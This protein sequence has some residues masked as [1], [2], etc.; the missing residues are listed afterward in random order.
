MSG[1]ARAAVVRRIAP[2]ARDVAAAAPPEPLDL[3]ERRA[4]VEG[5][6]TLLDGLYAHLPQKRAAYGQD[7]VQRLRVLGQRLGALDEPEF[8]RAMFEIV[9]A[10]RDGHT[11]YIGP[12]H[13]AGEVAFL[14][15]LVERCTEPDGEHVVVSKVFAADPAEAQA[16]DGAG[17]R[18]GVEVTH[19]NGVPIGRALVVYGERETGGRP[20]ARR[21]RALESLTLR[22]LRF[23]PPPDEDWV[24]VSFRDAAGAARAVRLSWRHA[25][26]SDAPRALAVEGEARLAYA[27]DGAAEAVRRVKKMLFA[28]AAWHAD[29]VAPRAAGAEAAELRD[30]LS[31]REVTCAAGTV[32]YLRLWSV[33]VRDDDGYLDAV[34]RLLADLPRRGLILDLRGNPGGLIWAAERL[35]QFFTPEPVSPTR[36]VLRATDLTRALARAPQG[37]TLFEGWRGSLEAALASGDTYSRAIALTPPERCNDIGQVYPGPVVAVVDARTY[38]AGDL[39]AAGFV[40]HRVGPLVAVDEATGAGGANVW[41]D[42][43]VMSALAGTSRAFPPLP[44]GVSFTVAF[45]RALRVGGV[46]GTEIEDAGVRGQFRHPLTRRD[47]TEGNEDLIAFCGR[48]LAGEEA[49]DLEVRPEPGGIAVETLNLDRIEVY[50]DD[51]PLGPPIAVDRAGRSRLHVAAADWSQLEVRGFTGALRRQLRRLGPS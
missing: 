15:L 50:A 19:W 4:V 1:D 38:S 9:T 3:E 47:L 24:V 44:K 41:Y 16:L 25:R 37:R 43:D 18:P 36:F 17:F 49:T 39:F 48:L 21:A 22:A 40:D 51:R 23:Q 26:E 35:L 2:A 45:R 20:D 10:L 46:E 8:H 13:V 34:R 11:R 14:P 42:R 31:A 6:V 33:D 29:T 30:A 5:F 7:P 27:G 12:E 32:A 28:P